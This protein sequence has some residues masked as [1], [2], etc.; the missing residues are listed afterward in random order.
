MSDFLEGVSVFLIGMMGAG[1]TTIGRLLAQRLGYRFLD[2]DAV[3]EQ[4]TKQSVA[5]VFAEAGEAEF[6]SLETQVLAELSTY[7]RTVTATGGGIVLKPENWSYLRH[8]LI[9]W[10]DVPVQQLQARLQGDTTRPLLQ[11]DPSAKLE[12]L[13]NQRQNLYAQADVRVTYQENET[14]EQVVDRTLTLMQQRIRP[15]GEPP[16]EQN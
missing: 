7:V 4:F 13:L 11:E 1:K 6:R 3:I 12:L 2:T 14:P 16:G 8:G 9:V 5:Q 15:K 10:L